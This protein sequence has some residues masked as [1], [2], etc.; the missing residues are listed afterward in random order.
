MTK[1]I[2]YATPCG[3]PLGRPYCGQ[4]WQYGCKSLDSLYVVWFGSQYTAVTRL[5]TGIKVFLGQRSVCFVLKF[6]L[7][8]F[9]PPQKNMH[10]TF[11]P[12][13]NFTPAA[14]TW[15]KKQN[16][17]KHRIRFRIRFSGLAQIFCPASLT[18]YFPSGSMF[19]NCTIWWARYGTPI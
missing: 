19:C 3:I 4:R 1:F 12:I 14:A 16:A 13:N 2:F 9:S 8:P 18:T 17:K 11:D 5:S 15:T 10:R 6:A 7:P